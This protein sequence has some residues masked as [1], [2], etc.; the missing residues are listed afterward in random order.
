MSNPQ[1]YTIA[2]DVHPHALTNDAQSHALTNDVQRQ[3]IIN[4]F[5]VG[6]ALMGDDGVAL[7]LYKFTC[8]NYRCSPGVFLHDVGCM[9]MDML[10]YVQQSDV[11]ITI[12]ALDNTQAQ[13]G[14]V[15]RYSCDEM[16][17]V[18][19]TRTSLHVMR[20]PDLFDAAHLLGYSAEGIC[21]GVQ[22]ASGAASRV[23]V[24]LSKKVEEAL[25][26]LWNTL[27]AQLAQLNAPFIDAHTG[28]AV[29]CDVPVCID[30]LRL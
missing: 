21:L 23:H 24:G 26:L 20:L 30:P 2:N 27:A 5:F 3:K 14:S 13:T 18:Q 17:R 10:S 12:D 16:A 22:I 25:P 11:I 6:N 9:S 29:C 4:V 15:F 8:K 7:A 28:E 1:P 19:G